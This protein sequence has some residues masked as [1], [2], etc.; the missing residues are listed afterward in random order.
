[1]IFVGQQ[2]SPSSKTCSSDSS[3]LFPLF[4]TTMSSTS[5]TP[6]ATEF[7]HFAATHALVVTP[8]QVGK[9]VATSVIAATEMLEE[10]QRRSLF[11]VLPNPGHAGD[12]V[13]QPTTVA[14]G[15]RPSNVPRVLRAGASQAAICHALL[16]SEIMSRDPA[17]R[18]LPYL[19]SID[20]LTEHDIAQR[21]HITPLISFP[22]RRR[23]IYE[24]VLSAAR[25]DD[26][27]RNM[28]KRWSPILSRGTGS[29]PAFVQ[30][31]APSEVAPGLQT[32]L[33]KALSGAA[34]HSTVGDKSVGVRGKKGA[35]FQHL[36]PTVLSLSV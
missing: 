12:P 9:L 16:R 36:L 32:A 4:E 21:G 30:I 11:R 17:E 22:P 5:A 23:I 20:W 31:A 35:T 25:S 3:I 15:M 2:P 7:A 34:T 19:A 27:I 13:Y 14:L 6:E 24:T 28:G 29:E 33:D 1:M 10:G 18:W 26:M 8:A